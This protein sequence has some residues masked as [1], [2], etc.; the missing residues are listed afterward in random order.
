MEEGGI[1]RQREEGWRSSNRE[2]GR[3]KNK[4]GMDERMQSWREDEGMEGKEGWRA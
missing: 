2:R 1:K 4:V 3:E